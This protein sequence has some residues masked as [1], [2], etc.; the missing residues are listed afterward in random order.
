[1]KILFA[2][3]SLTMQ[4]IVSKMLADIGYLDVLLA[5]GG[6]VVISLLAEHSDVGLVLLDW[7]MP[8]MNGIDCLKEIKANPA[9]KEIPVVMLTSEVSMAS[10]MEAVRCGACNYLIKP[11]ESEKLGRVIKEILR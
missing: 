5:D 4:K 6:D 11:F 9:T 10:V 3:D 7:N 8:V 1:M 2:D